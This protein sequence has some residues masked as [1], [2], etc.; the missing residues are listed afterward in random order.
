MRSKAQKVKRTSPTNRQRALVRRKTGGVCHICGGRLGAKWVVDHVKPL[1]KGGKN[2]ED[3]YLPACSTCNRLK[4]HRKPKA[5]KRILRLGIYCN[6]LV[7][8]D[9][10][11]GREIHDMFRKRKAVVRSRRRK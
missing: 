5:I 4:W 3:N 10:R 7:E 2:S 8:E 1:A 9:T 6:K 11:L